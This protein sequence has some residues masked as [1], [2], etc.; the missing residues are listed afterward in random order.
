MNNTNAVESQ[1][2]VIKHFEKVHFGHKIPTLSK[3]IPVIVKILAQQYRNRQVL[4]DNK[5]LVI[6]HENPVFKEGLKKASWILNPVG[7]AV[8]HKGILTLDK[9]RKNIKLNE[10]GTIS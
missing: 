6:F 9:K 3:F 8:Y 5:R 7:L 4:C 1:F 2:R 10:N